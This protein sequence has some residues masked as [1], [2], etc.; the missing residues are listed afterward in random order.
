[1]NNKVPVPE[2]FDGAAGR[3]KLANL[4]FKL[5]FRIKDVLWAP[6][7]CNFE[8]HFI[9]NLNPVCEMGKASYA[10][11]FLY[12]HLSFSE[13]FVEVDL[14]SDILISLQKPSFVVA[15]TCWLSC[16]NERISKVINLIFKKTE[17]GTYRNLLYL[18][19]FFFTDKKL[20][21]YSTLAEKN[22]MVKFSEPHELPKNLEYYK[23]RVMFLADLSCPDALNSLKMVFVI[24]LMFIVSI[25]K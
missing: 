10:V 20:Q 15:A 7:F 9:V 18:Q 3:R 5:I 23:Q 24:M 22:V 14:V 16:K 11:F 12:I 4:F 6:S 8:V 25:N 2:T 13:A 1:M 19:Y 17:L 21:L